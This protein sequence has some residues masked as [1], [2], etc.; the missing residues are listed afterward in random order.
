MIKYDGLLEKHNEIWKKVS[1]SIKIGFDKMK[2]TIKNIY[3]YNEKYLK[4]KI[5]FYEGK[6]TQIFMMNTKRR[7]FIFIVFV[8]Q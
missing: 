2:N 4:T 1:N 7:Y 5:K 8:H 3:F 6:I